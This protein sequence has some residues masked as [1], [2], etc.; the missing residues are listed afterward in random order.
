ML[1][2]T[3][4]S[5]RSNDKIKKNLS[6]TAGLYLVLYVSGTVSI[7]ECIE[8]FHEVSIRWWYTCYHERTATT[9]NKK[10]SFCYTFHY[11]YYVK[12]L[13]C[14]Q[15]QNIKFKLIHQLKKI[16]VC[17]NASAVHTSLSLSPHTTHTLLQEERG[18]SQVGYAIWLHTSSK[19]NFP[20]NHENSTL[21]RTILR[22]YYTVYM[23]VMPL[24][25]YI[26]ISVHCTAINKNST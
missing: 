25:W 6:F 14:T 1:V 15:L 16:H 5:S 21:V 7:F 13:T 19:I 24:S 9:D 8:G 20:V 18:Y 12:R 11:S 26:Y 23:T 3:V 22:S 10:I 17:I 4:F 2:S